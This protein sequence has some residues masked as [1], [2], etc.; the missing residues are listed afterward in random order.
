MS[1][2]AER[3]VQWRESF[4]LLSEE[5]FFEI[6]RMYLGEIK[7]P[8][9]KQKLIEQLQ[10]FLHRNEN[11]EALA[12]LVTEDDLAVICAVIFIPEPTDEKLLDFFAGEYS[13]GDLYEQIVNLEER[14]ILYRARA[15][16][17]DNIII[18]VNPLLENVLAPYIKIET[19]LQEENIPLDNIL[20]YNITSEMEAAFTAYISGHCDLCKMD[21]S[22]K[23]STIQDL[24]SIFPEKQE[25]LTY[26][27]NAYKNL[28]LVKE[29][30]R[31]LEVDW[32]KLELFSSMSN[33]ERA[34]YVTAASCVHLSR[35]TIRKY[36][37]LLLDII[38]LISSK[39]YSKRTLMRLGYLMMARP[40]AE[41]AAAGF[42][43]QSRFSKMLSRASENSE[44][45][46]FMVT[47]SNKGILESMFEVALQTGLL[48]VKKDFENKKDI[49]YKGPLFEKANT[50]AV[51]NSFLNIDAGFN[52]T[53]FPGYEFSKLLPLMKFMDIVHFDTAAVFEINRHSVIRAFDLGLS[54][55]EIVKMLEESTGYKI[56]ETLKVSLEE[57]NS[58]Y[59]AATLYQGYVLKVD[60]RNSVLIEN[61]PVIAPLIREV[62][63]KGIY[64]LDIKNEEEVNDLI[65]R[66]SLD[67]IGRA[68]TSKEVIEPMGFLPLRANVVNQ[69]A[70]GKMFTS[71]FED[72]QNEATYKIGNPKSQ[73]EFISKMIELLNDEDMDEEYKENL[74]LKVKRGIILN[75]SQLNPSSV[76]LERMSAEGMDLAGK[77]YV[78][79]QAIKFS[80]MVEIQ[81]DYNGEKVLGFPILVDRHDSKVTVQI[82]IEP[83]KSVKTF[84]VSQAGFIR[85]IRESIFRS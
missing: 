17:S 20:P 43:G 16:D 42:A 58:S 40:A 5:R 51:Q 53:V 30:S 73:K 75:E 15:E 76:R 11:L 9:N 32:K 24:E 72:I 21:G 47:S 82:R 7:T 1:P 13:L 48:S 35:E 59:S 66:S 14:L 37:Q 2:H 8:Y 54:S 57:W 77:I 74:R 49:F 71:G 12:N 46:R 81:F 65:K 25:N 64:L 23:K 34:S 84:S 4:L 60:E 69:N 6:M 31:G 56:S 62:L 83:D 50:D 27:I 39:G 10:S 85:R 3:V 22:F 79:E 26:L 19:L 67:F 41:E 61:N 44:Q 52:V 78:L 33:L 63:A 70:I 45:N 29:T 18:A 38:P 68:K 80:E 36:S 28:G 55:K